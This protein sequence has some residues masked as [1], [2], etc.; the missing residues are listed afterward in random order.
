MPDKY[1][2]EQSDIVSVADTI[3]EKAETTEQLMWPE[4]FKSAIKGLSSLNF[5]VVGGTT[6]PSDPKENTIWVNT[7]ETITEWVVSAEEPTEPIAGMV[8]I[9]TGQKSPA[10]FNILQ[11]NSVNIAIKYV[12]Q[13]KISEEVGEWINK[14]A[15]VYQNDSWKNCW[16]LYLFKAG[17]Q[18]EY[19]TGGWN[20][21]GYVL[22]NF[23]HTSISKVTIGESL[24]VKAVSSTSDSGGLLGTQI[25]IDISSFKTLRAK[26]N[27]DLYKSNTRLYIGISTTKNIS[28]APLAYIRIT[29]KG[30]FDKTLE[31]PADVDNVYVFVLAG[32]YTGVDTVF[33]SI[34][35]ISEISFE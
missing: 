22:T 6:Q 28:N 14:S 4:G 27:V 21:T 1:V 5:E 17:D 33:T 16:D 18:Y 20:R 3:R 30:D 10:S 2:V 24:I 32:C 13:Y 12:K 31:L 29:A 7:E 35:T 25:P 9:V 34:M 8:W 23:N 19:I 26:G 15:S 11:K